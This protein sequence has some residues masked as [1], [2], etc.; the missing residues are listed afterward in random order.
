MQ[1]HEPSAA[2]VCACLGS[3][4]EYSEEN[5]DGIAL[6]KLDEEIFEGNSEGTV[7]DRAEKEQL[8]EEEADGGAADRYAYT[9]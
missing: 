3:L 8:V 2:C 5:S 6:D 4:E 1:P 9:S 7:A